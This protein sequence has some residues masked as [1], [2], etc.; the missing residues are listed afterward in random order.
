MWMSVSEA[1]WPMRKKKGGASGRARSARRVEEVVDELM[2]QLVGDL[3]GRRR[4]G[5][6][7]WLGSAAWL[8]PCSGEDEKEWSERKRENDMWACKY[9]V[10]YKI[11]LKNRGE[12]T[13]CEIWMCC[14]S[15]VIWRKNLYR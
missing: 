4:G 11:L 13:K 1:W 10:S 6:S 14:W 5:E 12:N 15:K 2:T 3:G 9:I 8:L 7:G